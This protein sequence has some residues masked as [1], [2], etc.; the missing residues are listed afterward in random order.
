MAP[1]LSDQTLSTLL[2][3][4]E[5]LRKA[6]AAADQT[7]AGAMAAVVLYDA[8]V[9]T[10]CK[11][12]L[13]VV[14]PETKAEIHLPQVLDKLIEAW[15][16]GGG[17]GV[18]PPAAVSGARTLRRVRNTVQHDGAVPSNP[19]VARARSD[20]TACLSWAVRE[21]LGVEFSD[22]TRSD[23][24]ADETI[25]GSVLAAEEA[26]N[27]GRYYDGLVELAKALD[28][29]R[30][31]YAIRPRRN[32]WSVANDFKSALEVLASPDKGYIVHGPA[33]NS[34][35]NVIEEMLKRLEEVEQSLDDV[36]ANFDRS[37]YVWFQRVTP[38]VW[39]NINGEWNVDSEEEAPQV[40]PGE[41][42]RAHGFVVESIVRIQGWA[43]ARGG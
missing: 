21:L 16:D 9:E 42:D 35:G 41:F 14:A 30:G 36:A 26:A 32:A 28:V 18:R 11:V 20:A 34:A 40:A 29:A 24:I 1:A 7:N 25:R 23:A 4:R 33:S 17:T 2:V 13:G 5:L 27:E 31:L 38:D 6:D 12:V 39:R 10:G 37:E 3:A 43:D 22:L 8:A 19:Q 15:R